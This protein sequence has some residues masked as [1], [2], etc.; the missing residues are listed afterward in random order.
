MAKDGT[1]PKVKNAAGR[2]KK[3]SVRH[4][5]PKPKSMLSDFGLLEDLSSRAWHKQPTTNAEDILA[6]ARQYLC[7][8][9]GT[10]VATILKNE[11]W[12]QATRLLVC[13]YVKSLALGDGTK[14]AELASV[15]AKRVQGVFV[16]SC[17]HII[18]GD[19]TLP[20]QRMEWYQPMLR[21]HR[22]KQNRQKA[23]QKQPSPLDV[24]HKRVLQPT[25]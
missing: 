24:P 16:D 12:P 1:S 9:V 5:N 2:P 14:P 4:H 20:A 25:G 21:R 13:E 18:L 15:C 10:Q 23:K 8:E 3:G 17:S 11:D 7:A 22:S 19:D 6:Q